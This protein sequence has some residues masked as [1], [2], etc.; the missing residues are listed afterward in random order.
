MH[1]LH[2][3]LRVKASTQFQN[4]HFNSFTKKG[5]VKLASNSSGLYLLGESDTDAG[6]PIQATF[7]TVLSDWGTGQV[8]RPRFAYPHYHTTGTIQ[9]SVVSGDLAERS[10][11][12]F[13]SSDVDIRLP[14]MMKQPFP[15]TAARKYWMFRV[16]NVAGADFVVTGLSVFFVQ[17]P[18]GLSRNT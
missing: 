10:T 2:T 5:T 4:Y 14:Q 11:I 18:H 1:T 9:L 17:R 6:S 3:N 15:R 16:E 8:K 13:S 7:D 12:D